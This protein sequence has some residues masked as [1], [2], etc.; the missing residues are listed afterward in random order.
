MNPTED[1]IIESMGSPE[2]PLVFGIRRDQIPKYLNYSDQLLRQGLP[3]VGLYPGAEE[4]LKTLKQNGIKL[5]IASTSRRTNLDLMM[6]GTGLDKYFDVII[7]G[8]ESEIKPD[9]TST[10]KALSLLAGTDDLEKIKTESIF[11]G[12]TDKDLGA[13]KNAG[14]DSVLFFPEEH[15]KFYKYDDLQKFNPTYTV[16]DLEKVANIVQFGRSPNFSANTQSSPSNSA[17]LGLSMSALA[18]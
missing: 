17:G 13:A 2:G 14:I 11:I 16:K 6:K 4:L 10:L 18:S 15:S 12:D 9:P 1:L 5:A 8:D 3:H 7:A